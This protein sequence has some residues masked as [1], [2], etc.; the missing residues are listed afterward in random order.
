ME[1]TTGVS[2]DG[3]YELKDVLGNKEKFLIK[4][5]EK[6]TTLIKMHE[7]YPFVS[8]NKSSEIKL[9]YIYRDIRDVAVSLKEKLNIDGDRLI[10]MLDD[11]IEQSNIIHNSPVILSQ[12]YENLFTDL[13]GGI[14]EIASFLEVELSGEQVLK[15][16]KECSIEKVKINV[17]RLSKKRMINFGKRLANRLGVRTGR[18][19]KKTLYHHNH[20]SKNEGSIGVWRTNLTELEKDIINERYCD[21]IALKKY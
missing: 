10:E 4:Q 3:F 12:R 19:H 5:K 1:H 21:W 2:V 15:I 20:I 18:Y 17:D 7:V 14:H 8:Q 11:A 9:L 6:H 16:E 13:K